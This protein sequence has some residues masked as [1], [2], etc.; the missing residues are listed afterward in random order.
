M[1]FRNTRKLM[2]EGKWV[3]ASEELLRSRYGKIQTPNRALYN[4]RQLALCH[5]NDKENQ[6]TASK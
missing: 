2:Q 3:E 5:N 1:G 4:S 6:R